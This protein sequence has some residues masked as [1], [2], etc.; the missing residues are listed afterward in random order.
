MT[1]TRVGHRP[2]ISRKACSRS[3]VK[4]GSQGT[5]VKVRMSNVQGQAHITYN[6]AQTR[7]KGLNTKAAPE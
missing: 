5:G 3:K 2:V 4:P 1:M 6:V 7:S